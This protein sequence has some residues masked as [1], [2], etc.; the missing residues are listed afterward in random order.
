MYLKIK[1]K[2]INMKNPNGATKEKLA[3]FLIKEEAANALKNQKSNALKK[4]DEGNL[5]KLFI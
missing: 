3:D 1:L 5:I 2:K 4:I